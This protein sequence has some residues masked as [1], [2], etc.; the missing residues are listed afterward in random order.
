MESTVLRLLRSLAARLK[1]PVSS[2]RAA[3]ALF[4]DAAKLVEL[5]AKLSSPRQPAEL[6]RLGCLACSSWQLCFWALFW[7]PCCTTALT[8]W[9]LVC[10][11]AR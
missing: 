10:N 9:V 1:V 4:K 11:A 2:S 8:L 6:E 3:L 7:H 5:C